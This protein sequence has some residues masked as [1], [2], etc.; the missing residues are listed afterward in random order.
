MPQSWEVNKSAREDW[1]TLFLK[2][3]QDIVIRTPK[4]S[5]LAR[6]AGFNR[7][8]VTKFFNNFEQLYERYNLG[9]TNM[10]NV[11]ETGLTTTENAVKVLPKR[12]VNTVY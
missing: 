10:Y 12:S 6:S 7:P 1:L 4:A 8:I 11:D 2:R 5:S 9:P 3:N